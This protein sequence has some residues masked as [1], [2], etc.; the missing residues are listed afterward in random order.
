MK[1]KA[2]HLTQD[3][4]NKIKEDLKNRKI[5]VRKEIADKIDAARRLGDLS[6]NSA[7]KSALEDR[8]INE[9]RIQELEDMVSHA[10]IIQQ[11]VNGVVSLGSEVSVL[12]DDKEMIYKIV[13]A[14]EADP[15]SLAIS[16][17]SPIG[18]ALIG[19]REGE[20]VEVQLPAGS[21]TFKI[22]KVQ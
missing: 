10:E 5:V 20:E 18:A 1:D 16:N 17:E 12:I 4:Y 9:K 19:K 22:I 21:R 14:T 2:L 13:G 6:E 7:Y 3:G 11:T 8:T 15:I